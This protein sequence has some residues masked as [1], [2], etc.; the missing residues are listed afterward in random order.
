MNRKELENA[1]C[2]LEALGIIE[3]SGQDPHSFD[4]IYKL[5]KDHMLRVINGDKK[6]IEL[7][8]KE[9]DKDVTPELIADYKEKLNCVDYCKCNLS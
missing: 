1:I 4:P 9:L 5:S 7:L 2:E 3:I 8:K 6:E